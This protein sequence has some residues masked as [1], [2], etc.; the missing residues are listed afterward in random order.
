MELTR[1][2]VD[3]FTKEE[4]ESVMENG[5]GMN[6]S[7]GYVKAMAKQL[8]SEIDKPDLWKDAPG[9]AWHMRGVFTDRDE[10]QVGEFA[11]HREP[12]KSRIDEIAEEVG[13]EKAQKYGWNDVARK[14]MIEAVKSAI[15]KD[16]EERALLNVGK[17]E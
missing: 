1:E 4:L 16:R 15:L 12:P 14:C 6:Y 2:D 8:L 3:A 9:D 11:Y 5:R 10:N 13:K 17:G 7:F